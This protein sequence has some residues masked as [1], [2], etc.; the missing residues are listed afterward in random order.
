MRL[1][2]P[3]RSDRSDDEKEEMRLTDSN[4]DDWAADV[5]FRLKARGL[6][7]SQIED[8][9][10]EA[11]K[12]ARN[13]TISMETEEAVNERITE[14]IRNDDEKAF[15]L[16]GQMIGRGNKLKRLIVKETSA[17]RAWKTLEDHFEGSSARD[18]R[19]YRRDFNYAQ[20]GEGD[21][22]NSFILTLEEIQAKTIDTEAPI[23]DMEMCV[24]ILDSLPKSWDS[25]IQSIRGSSDANEWIKL[26]D[27]LKEEGKARNRIEYQIV[28]REGQRQ[29]F[30]TEK[31]FDM[32]CFNCGRK[33]HLKRDCLFPGGGAHDPEFY[34]KK[35]FKEANAAM[36]DISDEETDRTKRAQRKS[37]PATK[38][39]FLAELGSKLSYADVVKGKQQKETIEVNVVGKSDDKNWIIDSGATHH[40]SSR[41]VD[42]LKNEVSDVQTADKAKLH[43]VGRGTV[44]M[45][46][47]SLKNVWYVP[48]IR[49]NLI[50]VSAMDRAGLKV[51]FHK[52]QVKILNENENLIAQGKLNEIGLYE[53]LP[54][55][56]S[57]ANVTIGVDINL[58]HK[59]LGH[60]NFESLKLYN[61][62]MGQGKPCEP[63]L[64]SKST[65]LP[66]ANER[67]KAI[68]IL[69]VIHIDLCEP[70][71][72]G[73]ENESYFMPIVDEFTDYTEVVC[74]KTKESHGIVQAID[75]YV[76]RM[77][78]QTGQKVKKIKCDGGKE[79]INNEFLEWC[80]SR[81]III[82]Q[83]NPYTPQQ[84]GTAERKNRTLVE[85]A[86][87]LLNT[88]NLPKMFWP[89][90]ITTAAYLRN[91][92][93]SR[94]DEKSAME[95]LKG[96][97]PSLK[98]LRVFGCISYAHIPEAKR[99]KLDN[100]SEICLLAGYTSNGY[101]L[102]RVSDY[103]VIWSRNVRF[104][105]S[106]FPTLN[107][108][109][110]D[111]VLD[112]DDTTEDEDLDED[113]ANDY[114]DESS[115]YEN[116][117]EPKSPQTNRVV[118]RRM[119]REENLYQNI[120]LNSVEM[121]A[122][123]TEC[124]LDPQTYREA[125]ESENSE[126]W[127]AA[128][129]D[130]LKSLIKNETWSKVEGP[131]TSRA[132]D[133]KWVFNSK[134]DE[135]GNLTIR[136]ARLV[137]KG[138]QQKSGIDYFETYSPVMRIES[139]RILVSVATIKKMK[140][141]QVDVK[142]AF[143]NSEI[144]E[145]VFIK[146]PPGIPDSGK[147]MKLNKALYGL[148][149][150]PKSWHDELSK[151]LID[152]G[153]KRLT[154]DSGLFKNSDKNMIIGIWIDDMAI[155]YKSS[156]E[157]EWFINSLKLV[158]DIKEEE[159][160]FILKLVIDWDDKR[161]RISQEA[162][163]DKKAKEFRVNNAKTQHIPMH[164]GYLL[165]KGK[166]TEKPY[167]TLIGSLMHAMVYSRPDIAYAVS[168]L[169]TKVE[170]P[171]EAD[172]KAAIRVLTYLNSTKNLTIEYG[173]QEKLEV[174]VDAND[175][176]RPTLGFT[177]LLAGGAVIWRS[178]KNKLVTLSS[179]ESEFCALTEA[180]Q[181]T[182]WLV[183]LLE[184]LDIK[185]PM[186]VVVHEDNQSCMAIAEDKEQLG[187]TKHLGRRLGFVRD[188]IENRKIKLEYCPT[189]NQIA[190]IFTKALPMGK[191][192]DFRNGLGLKC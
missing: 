62:V 45:G 72:K 185:L 35:K 22:I 164:K 115:V 116:A 12:V 175:D 147:I 166:P 156:S 125:M 23:K 20:M 27:R 174:Y 73:L 103:S 177:I 191:F 161:A 3:F 91:R 182:L 82:D 160:R 133:C 137:A 75:E 104:I 6:Y 144:K 17:Y 19:S 105:E 189:E 66:F 132:V 176:I 51:V 84:N 136:K 168:V 87:T 37:K 70:D 24:K 1:K 50:S 92:C 53:L 7:R 159:L 64:L 32:E 63:C 145:N 134:T 142:T 34:K 98:H 30:V 28:S 31:K 130:E 55:Y 153:F 56:Y 111:N 141:H 15:G 88:A 74:F 38:I 94:M 80:R 188:A 179:A 97:K 33:G 90:A 180:I 4:Y 158:Y 13:G 71:K 155:L 59:R 39:S 163:I 121:E 124:S 29:A 113:E 76:T 2:Q 100:K 25:F 169:A 152:L 54:R 57:E 99:K 149:Q 110:A 43:T 190:D 151:T 47:F 106:E 9:P 129:E 81:G 138:Y 93:P 181:S 171:T 18:L 83:S 172:Y 42:N 131:I 46:T 85:T 5:T 96:V 157:K 65:V 170:D 150:G 139:L 26:K 143:L 78:R 117:I 67:I 95:R 154:C 112:S 11:R 114:S 101:K 8:K 60:P 109:E 126:E 119:A 58:M 49:R 184:E 40:M 89:D 128:I 146:L 162:Y 102:R 187:R 186:P 173:G 52:G 183:E 61:E 10:F 178:K 41:P 122:L 123:I 69:E 165:E 140:M 135:F 68:D 79:F 16:I 127:K 44:N 120:E 48:S 21:S 148:K 14:K 107:Q 36:A 167:R 118:T 192:E 86:K 108:S 77:E